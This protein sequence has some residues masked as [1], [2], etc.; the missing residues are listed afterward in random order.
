MNK[1][2]AL[3]KHA[4][5]EGV[6]ARLCRRAL[7]TLAP[8]IAL[9]ALMWTGNAFAA[10][11]CVSVNSSNTTMATV[12]TVTV[13]NSTP[14]GTVLW[15]TSLTTQFKCG[16]NSLTGAEDV[17]V[18]RTSYLNVGNG[19]SLYV[20]YNGNNGNTLATF[21]TGVS[22]SAIYQQTGTNVTLNVPLTVSLVK[23]G[24]VSVPGTYTVPSTYIPVV[25]V[26]SNGTGTYPTGGGKYWTYNVLFNTSSIG[27]TS[28]TCAPN[29]TSQNVDLGTIALGMSGSLG[30]GI[31]T[32]SPDV[33]FT[34]QLTCN[35]AVSG[36]FGIYMELDATAVNASQ[37][38]F[39]LAAGSTAS[40]VGIQVMQN[41]QPVTLAKPW[42][43]ASFPLTSTSVSVP[44]TAHYYQTNAIVSPGTANG[45]ATY[46]ITYQ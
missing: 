29:Q 30:T 2:G 34:V 43:I 36:T 31:G 13:S 39:S 28:S 4:G 23:T 17:F 38:I 7:R 5:D 16:L 25:Y 12:P 41:S 32:T 14:N 3:A 33:P 9:C 20:S 19:L 6:A 8:L 18:W 26:G 45:V 44:F 15:Q 37:G 46:T 21:D 27:V 24:T 40:G 1:A 42:Q 10:L 22:I 35:S 11:T